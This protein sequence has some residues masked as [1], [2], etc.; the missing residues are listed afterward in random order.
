MKLKVE[1]LIERAKL[2][3]DLV[4][5]NQSLF[6]ELDEYASAFKNTWNNSST[7]KANNKTYNSLATTC[8]NNF[9]NTMTSSFTPVF[10]Q[11]AELKAGPMI[12]VD[13][14][15]DVQRKL[16]QI[17]EIL[18]AYLNVSNFQTSSAE[19]YYELAK[20]TSALLI[21]ET[22]DDVPFTFQSIP[23]SKIGF[24]EGKNGKIDFIVRCN[25]IENRLIKETWK[26]AKLSDT[27]ERAI[28][29][30]P[31][32]KTEVKECFYYDYETFIWH[33]QVVI[34][35]DKHIIFE[36]TTKTCPI[37]ITRWSK[38]PG[39]VTGEGPLMTAL[40][41]I[42]TLNKMSEYSLKSAALNVFGCYTVADDGVMNPN[43][44]QIIPGGF[45][46]VS[47][48]G[49]PEGASI[50]ALP[51]VGSFQTQEFMIDKLEASIK[52]LMLNNNMPEES[53][54]VRTAFEISQRL[55]EGQLNIGA[56]Y[57]RLVFEFVI[58]TFRRI[59]EILFKTGRIK[60]DESI[61]IDGLFVNV[62]ITSP[63]AQEQKTEEL[64]KTIQAYSM[65][66]QI[67]PELA[68]TSFNLEALPKYIIEQM[69]APANTLRTD[70]E[71]AQLQATQQQQQQLEFMQQMAL[72]TGN[73]NPE[74]PM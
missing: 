24:L 47:R 20:G 28:K 56:S 38:V 61:D 32:K 8:V 44:L 27:L 23:L 65:V 71:I 7:Y 46:P 55:K 16:D 57:G 63:L 13:K 42:K 48:N 33:Y 3:R 43:S 49:G 67:S 1:K 9:I 66:A 40:P 60:T 37:V 35:G 4:M 6:E 58:P 22:T 39:V 74:Q 41:D 68:M 18:F 19:M 62:Q 2:A 64:N 69:G 29:D 17:T 51:T 36:S 25:E 52:K 26:K 59:L 73:I 15:D 10:A 14:R 11:W 31:T 34:E 45:I 30:N 54:A 70:E 53:A 12:E 21:T 72:K 5:E 50:T